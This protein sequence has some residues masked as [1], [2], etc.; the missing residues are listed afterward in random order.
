MSLDSCRFVRPHSHFQKSDY[1]LSVQRNCT[2]NVNSPSSLLQAKEWD[3]ALELIRYTGSNKNAAEVDDDSNNK[4]L[5]HEAL[6][7]SPPARHSVTTLTKGTHLLR[8]RWCIRLIPLL[9]RHSWM[10]IR[11]PWL[12]NMGGA[13]ALPCVC[14]SSKYPLPRRRRRWCRKHSNCWWSTWSTHRTF[15]THSKLSIDATRKGSWISIIA[16]RLCNEI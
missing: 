5:L 14:T 16:L 13:A 3:R 10:S 6:A 7:A 11:P 9:S 4:A 8:T 2:M 12:S 15:R 1:T